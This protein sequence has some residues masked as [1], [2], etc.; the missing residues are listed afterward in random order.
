MPLSVSTMRR[1]T[2]TRERRFVMCSV[3]ELSEMSHCVAS[4]SHCRIRSA[5]VRGSAVTSCTS[6]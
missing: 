5:N 2:G 3:L 1:R 4:S 6:V